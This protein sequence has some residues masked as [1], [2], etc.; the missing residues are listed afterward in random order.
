MANDEIKQ[1]ALKQKEFID[2]A[3][4]EL[5]TPTQ[6][7]L[8]YSDMILAGPNPNLKYIKII[9][10]NANRIQKLIANILDMAKIDDL[11]LKLNKEQFSLPALISTVVQDFRNQ[12][13]VNKQKVDLIYD[14]TTS[15]FNNVE[16]KV[17]K[18]VIVK[19]DKE[20][21]VQVLVNLVDNAI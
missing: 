6:A 18:D 19:A 4:H 15:S 11:S 13:K 21:I 17:N 16:E 7:I 1:L 5:R 14:D 3:A 2:I 20:R 8:G 12:I 9:A 10:R